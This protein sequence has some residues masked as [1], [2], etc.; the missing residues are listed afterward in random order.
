MTSTPDLISV[1]IPVRNRAA[2]IGN[3]LAALAQQSTTRPFEVLVADNGS[4]DETAAVVESFA[5]R[6]EHLEVIDASARRGASFARNL[7]AGRA[8]GEMLAFC[9]SDD[10]AH[11]DWLESLAGAWR[12]GAIV[13]GRIHP[14]R[15]APD[16]PRCPDLPAGRPR[17]L[18]CGFL[19]FADSA[20]LAIGRDDLRGIGGF[21]ETFP[22]S[23]DVELSWRAQV[24]GF[25]FADATDAV[26]FKR[27]APHGWIR[28]RQYHRWGR[29]FPRLYRSYRHE[30]MSRRSPREVARSWAALGLHGARAPFDHVHR[31]LAVRQAGW[32]TGYLIGS[33]RYRVLYF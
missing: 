5:D 19:P 6:F 20:N 9:D 14:L 15:L 12:P 24:A 17:G 27:G 1:V 28:F 25:E 3:Q 23:H 29:T 30:G 4:T 2:L 11:G 21:D 16:A 18:E 10:V 13:A 31:D 8:R 32:C 7:G 26:M 33:I 22:W